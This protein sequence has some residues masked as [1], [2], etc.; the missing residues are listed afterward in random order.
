MSTLDTAIAIACRAHTGQ[1]DKSGGA[2]ILH[3]LRLMLRFEDPEAQVVAVLHDVLEDSPITEAELAAQGFAAPIL[4]A[5]VCLTKRE[6]EPYEDFIRRLAPNPLARRVKIED[7]K[8]N[9]N[10]TRL[11]TLS[12][13]DLA[14]VRKYHQ[15][16]SYLNGYGVL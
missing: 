6:G 5:L 10:L 3:P 12:D 14:R 8:D 13:K 1:V 15:A 4:A 9:L 11:H 7:I 16:L 2:Y